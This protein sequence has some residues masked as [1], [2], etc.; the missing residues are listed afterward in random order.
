[1]AFFV[2][3]F[4]LGFASVGVDG[5]PLRDVRLEVA[6]YVP[7]SGSADVEACFGQAFVVVAVPERAVVVEREVANLGVVFD[8]AVVQRGARL[9]AAVYAL[10]KIIVLPAFAA[11][12]Q[13]EQRP[14]AR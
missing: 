7:A 8:F 6:F 4:G 13:R 5:K 10:Y 1:M 14:P 12:L 9:Q 11:E 2:L 3:A